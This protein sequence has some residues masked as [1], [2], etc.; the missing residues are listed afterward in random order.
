[1]QQQ[2]IR[3][4]CLLLAVVLVVS[5]IL[6]AACSKVA[7]QSSES[8]SITA[9]ATPIVVATQPIPLKVA[10]FSD[11]SASANWTKTPPLTADH[12]QPIIAAL[13]ERAGELTFGLI[14]DDSNKGLV[15][16]RIE[17]P[18]V[19]PVKPERKG[20]PFQNAK[21]MQNYEAV[22]SQYAETRARWEQEKDDRIAIFLAAGGLLLKQ[23]ANAPRSDVWNALAR[24]NLFLSEPDAAFSA[25]RRV[26]V[27]VSDGADTAKARRVNLKEDI[28]LILVNGSASVGSLGALKPQ[29]FES[30]EPALRFAITTD[31]G[32]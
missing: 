16:L 3:F 18:P 6:S 23:P 24:A 15:R 28:T 2:S 5:I 14:R 32:K 13:A 17:L 8:V 30:V 29:L 12:F 4:F 7:T 26:V 19:P 20:N 31:G 10:I 11:Q 22:R 27:L 21:E 25:A 9:S 1:M